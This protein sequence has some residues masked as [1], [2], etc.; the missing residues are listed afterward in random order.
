MPFHSQYGQDAL[1]GEVLF[2]DIRGVFVDVGARDGKVISNTLH[3]E[4]DRGWTGIAIEPHPDLFKTLRQTRHCTCFNVAASDRAADSM[5]FVRFLEE[6][7]GNSGLLSTFRDRERLKNIRH[8]IITVPCRPL[9]TILS[10]VRLVHYLDIDVEGHELAVLKGIDF[11]AVDI[12]VIGVE[13]E[14]GPAATRLDDYLSTKGFR[15]FLHLHS[16]RFY[17]CGGGVPSAHKMR[18]CNV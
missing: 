18:L 17:S 10:G 7:L 11:D 12:R 5:E 2:R 4:R 8:D 9:S 3:L 16:D 6:P 1:V 15:P 14:E 13:V